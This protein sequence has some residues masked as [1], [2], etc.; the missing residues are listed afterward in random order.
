MFCTALIGNSLTRAWDGR[1]VTSRGYRL[2]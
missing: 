1:M 2:T